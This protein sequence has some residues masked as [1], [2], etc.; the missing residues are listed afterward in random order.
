MSQAG[1]SNGSGGGPGGT[2]VKTLQGNSGGKVSPTITG[3][4]FTLGAGSITVVGNP[5]INTLVAQLTGLT[6]HSLLVGGAGTTLTNLGVASNGQLPIGSTGADPVLSTL[7]AG[8]GIT[9]VNGAGSI[10]IS[11]VSGGF[12]WTDVT[13]ATQTLA[14]ENG[15]VTDRAGG[16]T[17][18]LPASGALGDE[19][20]IM[21]KSGQ[22]SVAQN[23]GQQILI[24]TQ[25]S[26][27]GVTGSIASTS[28]SNS[29]QLLCI[30][31]G[32]NTVWRSLALSGNLTVA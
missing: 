7:T 30:T 6:N 18:T 17:Y 3:N 11:T 25:S 1:S 9:I 10:T 16:V 20:I 19:I 27:V 5:G 26:T 31:A 14:A 2:N 23:A 24:G 32:A 4:I 12:T 8:A 13:T 28:A 15:Y 22:W 29:V 21:G